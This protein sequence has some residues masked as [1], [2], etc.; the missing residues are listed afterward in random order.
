VPP[1]HPTDIIDHLPHKKRVQEQ[2]IKSSLSM[3]QF[4]IENGKVRCLVGKK[5]QKDH[6]EMLEKK[7]LE[8]KAQEK[9][10]R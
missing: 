9:V 10:K 5:A 4:I 1:G 2:F 3:Q 7:M 8:Q 6:L